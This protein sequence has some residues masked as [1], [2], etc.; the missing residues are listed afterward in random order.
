MI[1]LLLKNNEIK[2]Y[3]SVSE[4]NEKTDFLIIQFNNYTQT[5]MDWA[6]R[7]FD[8]DF[9][10]MA[11]YEDIEISSHFLEDNRQVSFHFSIPFYDKEKQLT[12][13]QLFIILSADRIFFF[14]SSGFDEFVNE[15]YS[16][17]L[18]AF[19]Q[20]TIDLNMVFTKYL[21]FI[22]D[23]YA[24]ITENLA[25]KVKTLAAKVLIEKRFEAEDMDIVT[26]YN[27]H[28]LL[29]KESLN[30]TMRIY[31]LLRKSNFGKDEL[32]NEHINTELADLIVV[33][34]YIQFNFDRLDDLKDNMNNKIDLE[35]NHI[36]K[37]LTVITLCLSLPT[38]IAGIYGMNFDVMPELK[39]AY[40]YPFA[41]LVMIL[42]AVLP[43]L[44]FKRKRWLK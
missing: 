42:A 22:S 12:E 26:Q 25:K 30:E 37:I 17:K 15:T 13:Q 14:Q 3:Q 39:W 20:Q 38:M 36:F 4:I 9:S 29:I 44:Y 10:I 18:S 6:K 19:Q 40:G 16:R 8:L 24:D 11:H 21:E 34:D 31:S 27:F 41:I 43:Y 23:Y 1:D 2:R 7:N 32:I 28:N 33:S 5:D 35:Q